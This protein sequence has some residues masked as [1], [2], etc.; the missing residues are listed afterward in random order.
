M[1]L[2]ESCYMKYFISGNVYLNTSGVGLGLHSISKLYSLL[3]FSFL[4]IW[5]L[6]GVYANI[7]LPLVVSLARSRTSA[8]YAGDEEYPVFT[9]TCIA[10]SE[11]YIL[12]WRGRPLS[13]LG[14]QEYVLSRWRNHTGT[15]PCVVRADAAVFYLYASPCDSIR[16]EVRAHMFH[17]Q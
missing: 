2:Y 9:L 1:D 7:R 12:P 14:F 16:R 10:S 17:P 15:A 13:V 3:R 4:Q 11:L 5:L 8:V 6:N